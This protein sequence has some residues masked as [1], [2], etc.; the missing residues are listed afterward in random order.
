M[1]KDLSKILSFIAKHHVMSLATVVENQPSVCSLFYAFDERKLS[2]V[3]ASSEDTPH[4]EH[5]KRM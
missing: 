5:I 4:I 2:F 3:V 1:S